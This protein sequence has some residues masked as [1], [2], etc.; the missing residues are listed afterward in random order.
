MSVFKSAIDCKAIR[1]QVPLADTTLYVV[2]VMWV[3]G[4]GA[5]VIRRA[6]VRACM[7]LCCLFMSSSWVVVIGILV[8]TGRV[9]FDGIGS[10]VPITG[11][12]AGEVVSLVS[13]HVLL[14]TF[15]IVG[16]G[17]GRGTGGGSWGSGTGGKVIVWPGMF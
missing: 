11:A 7:T 16:P 3:A 9:K 13:E 8:G 17:W 15:V 4:T 1:R 14:A 5:M 6:G 2:R 10:C 12:A